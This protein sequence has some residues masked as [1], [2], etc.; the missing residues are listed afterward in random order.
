M[1]LTFP[2]SQAAFLDQLRIA[3]VRFQL[4]H[5][6]SHTRLAGGSVISISLGTPLWTGSFVLDHAPHPRH[7]QM[8]AL[9]ALLDQ[10]GASF[11]C[12]DPRQTGPASDPEGVILGTAA[13]LLHSIAPSQQAL[14]I[15]ALPPFYQLGAGDMLGFT[16]GAAPLR[17]ALHRIVSGGTASAGGL[18]PEITV[19][20]QLRPGAA[21]GLP[22]TLI[23]PPCQARLLPDPGYGSG[24][25]VLSRD[26]RFG[27]IQIL[28]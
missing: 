18:S 16:Y 15:A 7:A 23:R 4:S 14:R 12:H 26:A 20:P 6:Q 13:P 24:R 1:S 2:L 9:I 25:Q 5:P 10:P 28:R 11:L 17:H 22:V 3:E 27:F 8:E 21:P 19:V